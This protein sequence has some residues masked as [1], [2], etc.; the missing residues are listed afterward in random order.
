[1]E[2]K[3]IIDALNWRYAT[4]GFDSEKKIPSD[5]FDEL[6]E[7]LRLSPSSFGL[8]PWKF[9]VVED[10]ELRE[11][12]KA[13]S[14]NQPQI[15]DA[16]HFIVLC[17]NKEVSGND[18]D[19]YIQDIAITRGVE[20]ESLDGFKAMLTGFRKGLDA[21]SVESWAKR[22]VYIALGLLLEAAALRGID[23]CPMEGF[24]PNG[25]D[26]ILGLENS[27]YTST[28]FCTL[29]YR[30]KND[31]SASNPKVRFSKEKVVEIR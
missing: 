15:T 4:K 9:I 24:D 6:T 3:N 29:G 14:W 31:K 18:I 10:K 5:E 22:Q 13:S 28:V 23:A 20:I 19:D 26:K 27:A 30:S 21:N 25:V 7:I 1:M 8:Q 12:I 11:K 16:S 2:N 17:A